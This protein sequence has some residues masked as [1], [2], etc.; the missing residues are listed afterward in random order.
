MLSIIPTTSAMATSFDCSKAL[1]NIEKTICN[2]KELGELDFRMSKAYF[3]LTSKLDERHAKQILRHQKYWLKARNTC[4]HDDTKC[5]IKSYENRILYLNKNK[6]ELITCSVDDLNIPENT[7]I[8]AGG[9]VVGKRTNFQIDQ[10]GSQATQFEVTVNSPTTPVALILSAYSPSIWNISWT[11]GT[12]I[13]A[14]I[15]TGYHRQVIAGLPS[16]T[17]TIISSLDHKCSFGYVTDIRTQ[18]DK[19]NILSN[20]VFNKNV[21]HI[22]KAKNGILVIGREVNNSETYTSGDTSPQSYIDLNQPLAGPAG[23][24][25]LESKG[26]IRKMTD[27]D[28]LR[29]QNIKDM[30]TP[31][32]TKLKKSTWVPLKGYMIL[33]EITLPAGL[34]GSYSA[35]FFLEEGVPY[36]KG[37][38]GHSALV[39]FNSNSCTGLGCGH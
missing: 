39:D 21:N 37:N 28:L 9:F 38:L 31:P 27:S 23:L 19:I 34:Y 7:L 20:K 12:Q 15:A 13:A 33:Q 18:Q 14:V 32:T 8:Y 25:E 17:P 6:R 16:E 36:P 22:Y 3:A 29:W 26:A 1:T 10:S 35:F 24:R 30:D 11:K 5:L 4:G 2:N